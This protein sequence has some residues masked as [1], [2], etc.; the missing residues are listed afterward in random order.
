[1]KERYYTLKEE[2]I[3]SVS[4]GIGAILTIGFTIPIISRAARLGDRVKMMSF[5]VYM[6]CLTL[7][8][9]TSTLYHGI[10]NLK[11]K[12]IFRIL[13]HCAI[14]LCI[15]GTYTPILLL[16]VGGRVGKIML[17]IVWALAVF[18]II[19][20]LVSFKKADLNKTEKLSLTLYLAMGWI[21]ILIVNKILRTLGIKFFLYIIF[22]GILYSVG[23]YFYKN[24]KIKFNHAIW[25][26]F[27]LGASISMYIGIASY[28]G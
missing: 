9:L 25:H 28:L 24:R 7:M 17:A 6:I 3:N 15:A 12:R 8:F 20:K 19:M 21:S 10:R 16:G 5:T 18:G 27:I 4:H 2:I 11:A 1:M 26:F 23:V 14:F 13:D 22:G